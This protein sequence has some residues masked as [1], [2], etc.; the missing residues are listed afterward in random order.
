MEGVLPRMEYI[1]LYYILELGHNREHQEHS[2]F[3]AYLSW[4]QLQIQTKVEWSHCKE[5]DARSLRGGGSELGNL[6]T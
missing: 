3:S 6:K 4:L 1:A 2:P 5:S